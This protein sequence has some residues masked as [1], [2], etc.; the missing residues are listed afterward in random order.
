VGD[1]EVLIKEFAVDFDLVRAMDAAGYVGR[2]KFR[3]AARDIKERAH[4]LRGSVYDD[5]R[6]DRILAEYERIAFADDDEKIKVS[7]KL[8]A[9]EMYRILSS[10]INASEDVGTVH[11]S[12]VVN[13]DYGE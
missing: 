3:R 10:P 5:G 1:A 2:G 6:R 9:L 13:Y 11:G 4:E 12:L 7:D 8:K